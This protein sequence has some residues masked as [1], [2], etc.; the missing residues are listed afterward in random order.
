MDSP[1]WQAI[2]LSYYDEDKDRLILEGVRPFLETLGGAAEAA[3]FLRHW[4]RGPHLRISVLA[5]SERFRTLVEPAATEILGRYLDQ[6]PSSTTLPPEPQL[7]RAH[8][9]LAELEREEGP[10]RPLVPNNSLVIEEHDRRLKVLG[11]EAAAQ[12]LADFYL[13]SNDLVF[14]MLETVQAGRSRESLGLSLM[15]A[16]AHHFRQNIGQGFISFRSHSEA[17]LHLSGARESTR[18]SFQRQYQVNRPRLVR[19]VHGV[20]DTVDRGTDEVPFVTEWLRTLRPFWE[21]AHTLIQSGQLPLDPLQTRDDQRP[22][23]VLGE[24]SPMHR[25]MSHESF[26][27]LLDEP[28]FK[29]YRLVLN[30]TYLHLARLGLMGYARYRLCHLAA[31]AVEDALGINAIEL[32]ERRVAALAARP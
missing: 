2:R 25:I 22:W 13:A 11:S 12:L 23:G 3:Y 4:R 10:L 18:A 28:E 5:T 26:L 8:Q 17:F 1:I 32:V 31:N 14:R 6:H 27:T 15:L 21:R 20:I 29:R 19:L 30:Y 7:L 24:R 16:V 9:Q